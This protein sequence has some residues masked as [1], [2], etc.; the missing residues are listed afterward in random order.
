MTSF[1]GWLICSCF[2]A[3]RDVA[4]SS[5]LFI[6]ADRDVVYSV[7]L[8]ICLRLLPLTVMLFGFYFLAVAYCCR[9]RGRLLHLDFAFGL[10][11]LFLHCLSPPTEKSPALASDP[12]SFSLAPVSLLCRRQRC[13]L[14]RL[15]ALPT[16][17]S[18]TLLGLAIGAEDAT[19]E[20]GECRSLGLLL[21][22]HTCRLRVATAHTRLPR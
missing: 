11:L 3:D 14:L 19:M 7:L 6:T 5:L 2:L 20:V 18:P 15:P 4:A 21:R 22:T 17:K 12:L 1:F 13:R 10:L 9:L 16:A 8:P